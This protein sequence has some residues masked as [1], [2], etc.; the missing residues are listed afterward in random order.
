MSYTFC[1]RGVKVFF[2][3]E[4]GM[5]NVGLW[6]ISGFVAALFLRMSE[7]LAPTKEGECCVLLQRGHLLQR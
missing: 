1:G 6:V 4:V 3:K 5:R 2:K 7:N